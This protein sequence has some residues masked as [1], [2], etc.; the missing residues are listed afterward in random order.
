M[1]FLSPATIMTGPKR[2]PRYGQCLTIDLGIPDSTLAISRDNRMPRAAAVVTMAARE[3]MRLSKAGEKVETVLVMGSEADPTGHPD[4]REITE[5]LRELRNKWFP[6]AK[7]CLVSNDPQ[8]DNAGVRVG[9]GA[10]DLP[11]LRFESG[12][13]KTYTKLTGRKSTQ[14]VEI[15]QQLSSL[16]RVI[17]RAHFVR[18]EVDNSTETEVRGWIKRLQDVRPTEIQISTDDPRSRGKSP[19]RG[20]P[21]S[22]LQQIIDEVIDKVGATVTLLEPADVTA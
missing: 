4:F 18:G 22:R 5:N 13:A 3:L 9:V 12:T 17:I 1:S 10:Y 19:S 2:S 14:L 21:K 16:D 8:L 6:R 20:V 7:L 11:V 15:V